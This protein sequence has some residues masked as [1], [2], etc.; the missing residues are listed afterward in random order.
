M[1][2]P[3]T[4]TKDLAS[5]L[6][7]SRLLPADAVPV[8]AAQAPNTGRDA[9]DLEA[10]RRLLVAQKHLT[11]YQAALLMRG[12]SEGFFL[13]E[14]KILEL[15]AKGRMAGVYKAAHASGQV[16]AIKVLPSSKA[17]DPETLARFR[18]EAKLLTRLDHPN[19]V[20]SFQIGEAD[21][22]HYLVL[23]YLD[24]DTLGEVLER[25]KT[26]PPTDAVRIVYQALLGL[27]HI[28]ERGMIHR[29]LNPSNL[30]LVG[31]GNPAD[32][33]V[34]ILDIGFGKAVFDEQA[35][36][37]VDDPSQLTGD[38]I[39]LGTPEYL[40]PE[41]AR[42]ASEADI[43]SDIYSLG[44]VLYHALTSQPPF[45]DKS[46]VNSV[47]R[48]ATEP[49]RPLSDFLPQVPD[50]LQNVLSW[51]MAKDPAQRYATPERAA[52][53][54]QLF[55][56]TAPGS[57][58][59]PNEGPVP[60]Y[61]QYLESTPATTPPPPASIPVG[62]L[63]T[64]GRRPPPAAPVP[65]PAPAVPAKPQAAAAV[66][67]AAPAGP[68]AVPAQSVYVEAGYDVELIPIDELGPGRE[69]PRGALDL[70]RREAVAACAGGAIVL[71]ALLLGY[72]VSRL[73]RREPA[74]STD[75]DLPKEG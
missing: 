6:A 67:M 11:E 44:C 12:H 32:R 63:E 56:R 25:R 40:A 34:K 31:A 65:A 54:L 68:I 20:R 23:E 50:G 46:V 21:G 29:D 48:H 26:L 2:T 28:H 24:G 30:M 18:R 70:N 41:Q 1:P 51:M 60:A 13:G 17:R 10:F 75:G 66:P 19:V 39:I 61:V 47:M 22:R 43:R 8:I 73:L 33:P 35:K 58:P 71:A 57:A 74:E 64:P 45:P 27:Q 69:P 37:P 15:L 72:G 9:D 52:T 42:K 59:G 36:S 16:V 55:L 4:T 49:A 3:P 38:G 5:L 14:Y 7:R 53:A 62:R